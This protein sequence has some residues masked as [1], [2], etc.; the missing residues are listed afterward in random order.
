MNRYMVEM[1]VIGRPDVVIRVEV[2]SALRAQ[3]VAKVMAS[4]SGLMVQG[5]RLELE[6]IREL[7]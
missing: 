1:A 5:T 4:L 3:A 6:A 7:A 2:E